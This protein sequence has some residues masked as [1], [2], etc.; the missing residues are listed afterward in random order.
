MGQHGENP[1]TAQ[2][3]R[4]GSMHRI[5]V[6][7]PG[8]LAETRMVSFEK[9]LALTFTL[10]PEPVASASASASAIAGPASGIRPGVLPKGTNQPRVIDEEDPYKKK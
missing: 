10:E 9:D 3:A 5:E 7:G 2:V 1:F 4:D 8:M 6:S